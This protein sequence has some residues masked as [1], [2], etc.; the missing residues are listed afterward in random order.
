M[1]SVDGLWCNVRKFV[2]SQLRSSSY[3]VKRTECYLVPEHVDPTFNLPRRFNDDACLADVLEESPNSQSINDD[4]VYQNVNEEPAP[5]QNIPVLSVPQVPGELA[6]PPGPLAVDPCQDSDISTTPPDVSSTPC[7][8]LPVFPPNPVPEQSAPPSRCPSPR[9]SS[10]P[11]RR[12]AY[13]RD[14]VC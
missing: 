3:R 2:G 6:T 14:Y 9:R 5:S 8:D 13:L 1:V 12:P 4:L 10:R 7:Q 11:S